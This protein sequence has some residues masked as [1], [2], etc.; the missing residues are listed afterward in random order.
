MSYTKSVHASS[1][2]SFPIDLLHFLKNSLF[3]KDISIQTC[4]AWHGITSDCMYRVSKKN[5]SLEDEMNCSY[6]IHDIYD[7][8]NYFLPKCSSNLTNV[9]QEKSQQIGY[10]EHRL[11][12]ESEM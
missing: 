9:M 12:F 2:I 7:L 4:L 5:A 8:V 10:R 1:F 3:W 6:K 11:E